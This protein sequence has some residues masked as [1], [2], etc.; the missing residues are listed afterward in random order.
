ML[1]TIK[2]L[3]ILLLRRISG[4]EA[5]G[6]ASMVKLCYAR[7]L[8]EFTALGLRVGG[9]Q[10]QYHKGFIHLVTSKLL[11]RYLGNFNCESLYFLKL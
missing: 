7:T 3:T 6:D 4:E 8:R 10:S 2:N 5:P 1:K 11:Q 9:L